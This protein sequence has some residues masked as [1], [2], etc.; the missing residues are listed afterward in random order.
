MANSFAT[1][2]WTEDYITGINVLFEKLYQGCYECDEFVSL[3]QTRM[4]AEANHGSKLLQI[5][6][7]VSLNSLGFGRDDGASLKA[8]FVSIQ[9]QMKTEGKYHLQVAERIQSEVIDRFSKW[10]SDHSQRVRYSQKTLDAKVT[11]YVKNKQNVDKIQKKY[12]N[13]C[14]ILEDVKSELGNVDFEEFLKDMTQ[15][16]VNEASNDGSPVIL[17]GYEYKYSDFLE[18][19]SK[20]L[21]EIPKR[22]FKRYLVNYDFCSTGSE[23]SSWVQLN[24]GIADI[25]K[26]EKFGQDL[27]NLGYIRAIDSGSFAIGS[28]LHY[29]WR[30]E[31]FKEANLEMAYPQDSFQFSQEANR[32]N[33]TNYFG[34]VK[35]L[36]SGVSNVDINDKSTI[37]KLV[38]ECDELDK[39]YLKEVLN[40]DEERCKLEV[41]ITDHLQFMEKCELDRLRA[42]KKAT[43]DFLVCL[44]NQAATPSQADYLIKLDS[45]FTGLTVAEENMQPEKDLNFVLENYQTGY[46]RPRSLVYD[47]FQSSK[48][49]QIFGVELSIRC[50]MERKIVPLIVSSILT[51]MDHSYGL[52]ENDDVRLSC[53]TS[54][55][56][57]TMTHELRKR[58][59]HILLDSDSALNGDSKSYE[60][61]LAEYD[62]P[63]VTNVLKLYLLEL[64]DS[65][66]TGDYYDSIKSLY[67]QFGSADQTNERINGLVSFLTS[68]PTNNIATLDA[69]LTHFNR[70]IETVK[71]NKTEDPALQQRHINDFK[72]KISHEFSTLVLRPKFN[73]GH[74]TGL[75]DKHCYKLVLD[76]LNNKQEIFGK[77]KKQVSSAKRSTSLSPA[78][79][80]PPTSVAKKAVN[81]LKRID[82]SSRSVENRLHNIVTRKVSSSEGESAPDRANGLGPTTS[83]LAE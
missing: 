41:T 8:S 46:Y 16:E 26:I 38:R 43:Q 56:Q 29:Q 73:S 34:E 57:L 28:Q 24:I 78:S 3:F 31:A 55:V 9:E 79:S 82:T 81:E 2:F 49:K 72:E 18:M 39:L 15:V 66:V 83:V 44:F 12:F 69:I 6:N 42:L 21:S 20:L 37:R 27:I 61:I 76:L 25:A 48:N 51:H 64:P 7:T 54:P 74:S 77:V 58:I 10:S 50:R 45:V 22:P 1:S 13:K 80:V 65:L 75:N 62:A 23:V 40:L 60:K 32:N 47:N 52:M 35:E 5:P 4:T 11:K 67:N 14:R 19:L 30:P 33:L 63:V 36:V 68:L 59:N 71:Q 53:W 17:A 70:I